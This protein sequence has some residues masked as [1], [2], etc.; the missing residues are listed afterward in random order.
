MAV[1]AERLMLSTLWPE[2]GSTVL[3]S[4]RQSYPHLAHGPVDEPAP[5]RQLKRLH[6]LSACGKGAHAMLTRTWR[7]RT[8]AVVLV[9]KRRHMQRYIAQLQRRARQQAAG[10]STAG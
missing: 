7:K 4:M 1:V 6:Y 3:H 5:L 10:S 2:T 8:L 9:C